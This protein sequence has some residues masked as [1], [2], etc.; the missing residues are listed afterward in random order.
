MTSWSVVVARAIAANLN[1]VEWNRGSWSKL[2]DLCPSLAW[3]E[4]CFASASDTVTV[5]AAVTPERV[6]FG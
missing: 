1:D 6:S 3:R 5:T 2:I 4:A